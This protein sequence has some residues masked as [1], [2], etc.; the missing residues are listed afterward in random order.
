MDRLNIIHLVN[1][2]D[3]NY[4]AQ[5]SRKGMISWDS[6]EARGGQGKPNKI[7]R[8]HREHLISQYVQIR[9]PPSYTWQRIN[10]TGPRG[11]QPRPLN[12]LAQA[13]NSPQWGLTRT[14]LRLY[15]GLTCPPLARF[16][17]GVFIH[18]HI[19]P[20][21]FRGIIPAAT[22][23]FTPLSYI[24]PFGN[25]LGPVMR[26]ELRLLVFLFDSN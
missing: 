8:L 5:N 19:P 24:F 12:G 15:K 2:D 9:K 18:C 3:Y 6:L 1:L 11:G 14:F 4:V 22:C 17:P 23:P 21:S 20:F 16:K 7:K 25:A 13:L 10:I 26:R